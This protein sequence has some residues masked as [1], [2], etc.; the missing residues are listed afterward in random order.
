MS[1]AAA[2]LS[3]E[4]LSVSAPGGALLI[5]AVDLTLPRG[6]ALALLGQP[7]AGIDTLIDVLLGQA[8][9]DATVSAGAIRLTGSEP[10]RIDLRTPR[11]MQALRG[12]RIG[13]VL[14]G[15]RDID[16]QRPA[17]AH[18]EEGLDGHRGERRERAERAL[19]IVGLGPGEASRPSGELS[20]DA[21]ER[22]A[23]AAALALAPDLLVVREPG[24]RL[25]PIERARLLDLLSR[26]RAQG[27]ALVIATASA[28][29][30]IRTCAEVVVVLGGQVVESG[31]LPRTLVR[32]HHPYTQ[33]LVHAMPGAV[34][35]RTVGTPPPLRA[36]ANGPGCRH[37]MAC[38]RARDACLR[39]RPDLHAVGG[40]QR[41]R[42]L[43]AP[44]P[45]GA[46]AE[47]PAVAAESR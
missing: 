3:V 15:G 26:V 27:P 11:G 31:P 28:D 33:R 46:L 38:P 29:T 19:G 4:G 36:W 5:D 34:A 24:A 42:C 13:A 20:D 25:D 9:P 22:T 21:R 41:A 40:G 23:I 18:V 12:R 45:L 44:W 7:D 47:P 6:G 14:A 30:A 35:G 32:P 2:I 37:E 1:S 8:H 10:A 17:R 16:P 43:F 39:Q